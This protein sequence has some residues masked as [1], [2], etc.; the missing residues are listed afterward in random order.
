M[1]LKSSWEF[2][3]IGYYKT[4]YIKV[5]DT[6]TCENFASG[7]RFSSCDGSDS[8]NAVQVQANLYL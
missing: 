4:E 8:A 3:C 2:S 1:S 6:N 5:V 7:K